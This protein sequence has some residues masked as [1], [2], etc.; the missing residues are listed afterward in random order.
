MFGNGK[1][2]KKNGE[3]RHYFYLIL[4]FRK[5]RR[6][7]GK[8]GEWGMTL[9]GGFIYVFG[10]CRASFSLFHSW[11]ILSFILFQFSANYSKSFWFLRQCLLSHMS[12]GTSFLAKAQKLTWVSEGSRRKNFQRLWPSSMILSIRK[13]IASGCRT[14]WRLTNRFSTK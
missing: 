8:R 1:R 13:L 11:K 3:W 2:R 9:K 7:K 12:G 5:W 6:T 4:N 10:V 14:S